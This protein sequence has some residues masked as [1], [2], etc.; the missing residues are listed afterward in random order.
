M[1]IVAQVFSAVFHPLFIL[2]FLIVYTYFSCKHLFLFPKQG[3]FLGFVVYSIVSGL[4]LPFI[5]IFMMRGLGLISS[6]QMHDK[7]E[8]IGPLIITGL[9]YVWL[10]YNYYQNDAVPIP[11]KILTLGATISL[12]LAFFL[13]NFQ[14]LSLHGVGIGGL[15][16]GI[17][18][19]SLKYGY[20]Y[21]HIDG[22]GNISILYVIVSLFIVSGVVLSSRLYLGAHGLSE[23]YHGVLVGVVGQIIALNILT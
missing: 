8:R 15:M 7:S 23:I 2:P 20:G 14:K 16:V 22:I 11:V 12:F 4:V 13:N 21:F 19:V 9:F 3:A 1:R 6:L 18:V 17:I 10:F 5:A